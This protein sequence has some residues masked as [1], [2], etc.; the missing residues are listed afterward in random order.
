MV[1]EDISSEYSS[2]KTWEAVRPREET[3]DW[4]VLVWFKSCVAKHVFNL[5]VTNLNMI[6]FMG[7][8][9]SHSLLLLF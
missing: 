6:G 8:E 1:D 7:N 2:S 4:S 5:W 9:Y 3:K